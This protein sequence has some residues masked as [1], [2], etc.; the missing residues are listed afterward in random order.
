MCI[1]DDVSGARPSPAECKDMFHIPGS[2]R[3]PGHFYLFRS[4]E[5]ARKIH[6]V[7]RAPTAHGGIGAAIIWKDGSSRSHAPVC[8]D[9]TE[10]ADQVPCNLLARG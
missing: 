3:N 5:I 8:Y 7:W 6:R 2:S 10:V 9:F 4:L 1:Q